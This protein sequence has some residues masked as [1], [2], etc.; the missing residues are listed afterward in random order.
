MPDLVTAITASFAFSTS[1]AC[2]ATAAT[3]SAVVTDPAKGQL[4]GDPPV[5]VAQHGHRLGLERRT[6]DP[7]HGGADGGGDVAGPA[8]R[9]E[10][11]Q[12]RHQR[13]VRDEPG[14]LQTL[15][16]SHRPSAE[17]SRCRGIGEHQNTVLMNADG[18][19]VMFDDPRRHAVRPRVLISVEPA[20]VSHCLRA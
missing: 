13:T 12:Y 1:V 6:V 16:F 5:P 3:D 17:Q 14:D 18:V 15:Q 4:V 19:G 8:Q 2:R 20:S 11:R 10:S 9:G 7:M